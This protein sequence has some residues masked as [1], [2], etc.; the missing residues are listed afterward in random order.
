VFLEPRLGM[1]SSS[2]TAQGYSAGNRQC[3]TS[4]QGGSPQQALERKIARLVVPLAAPNL[5]DRLPKAITLHDRH[6]DSVEARVN[7]EVRQIRRCT[8]AA[9]HRTA[10]HY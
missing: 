7:M 5:I 2:G 1:R 3:K 4:D 8:T 6:I 10:S 9:P